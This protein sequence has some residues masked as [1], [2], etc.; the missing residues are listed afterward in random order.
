MYV[1]EQLSSK[2]SRVERNFTGRHLGIASLQALNIIKKD[3]TP[4]K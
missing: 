1:E 4:K 2:S 3:I